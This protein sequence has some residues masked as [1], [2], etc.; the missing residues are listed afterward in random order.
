MTD[1]EKIEAIKARLDQKDECGRG[2]LDE[3]DLAMHALEDIVKIV[4]DLQ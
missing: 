4:Y 3:I 2:S 1:T